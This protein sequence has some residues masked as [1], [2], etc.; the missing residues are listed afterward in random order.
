MLEWIDF[1]HWQDCRGMERPGYVFEVANADDQRMLTTCVIPLDVPFDWSTL[2]I[3]FRL[4]PEQKPGHST[5][6][7]P[8]VVDK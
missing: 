1:S 7:P 3:K 5:P 2:P 8:S 4:V 6:L